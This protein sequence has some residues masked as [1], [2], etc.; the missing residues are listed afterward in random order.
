LIAPEEKFFIGETMY[1]AGRALSNKKDDL[2]DNSKA[3]FGCLPLDLI[4]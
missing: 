1:F 2:D 3:S 4:E